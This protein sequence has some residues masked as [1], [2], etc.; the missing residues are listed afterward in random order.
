MQLTRL[1]GV[2][3]AVLL[4]TPLLIQPRSLAAQSSKP[5]ALEGKWKGDAITDAFQGVLELAITRSSNDW[6]VTLSM[7][8]RD[9]TASGPAKV[10]TVKL[11]LTNGDS[12]RFQSDVGGAATTYAAVAL[13]DSLTG[14]MEAHQDGQLLG[15][16]R[17][18][19]VRIGSVASSSKSPQTSFAPLKVFDEAW[20]LV[21]TRYG[22]FPAKAI[23]WTLTRNIYRDQA[24]AASTDRELATVLNSMLAHLNDRHVSFKAGDTTYQPDGPT[25]RSAFVADSIVAK[26]FV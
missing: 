14:S 13:G 10:E 24:A 18:N 8:V 21:D 5:S 2:A 4:T 22:N 19:L 15:R 6:T 20:N 25:D 3:T 12:I 11:G 26:R 1:T 23:D 17:F 9:K 16:G 7:T